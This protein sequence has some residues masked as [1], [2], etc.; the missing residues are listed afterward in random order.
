MIMAIWLFVCVLFCVCAYCRLCIFVCAYYCM[1]VCM[2][3]FVCLPAALF[4]RLVCVLCIYV[5]LYVCMCACMC[6][7]LHVICVCVMFFNTKTTHVVCVNVGGW[8]YVCV[9]VW[10]NVWGMCM[11]DFI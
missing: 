9:H 1:D 6:L 4:A 5:W 2:Y 10:I 7:C 11:F 3:M 8:M